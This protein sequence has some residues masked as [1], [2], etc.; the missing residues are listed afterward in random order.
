VAGIDLDAAQ[1]KVK[2][3]LSLSTNPGG[4]RRL[5]Q[6]LAAAFHPELGITLLAYCYAYYGSPAIDTLTFD[7]NF[8][9]KHDVLGGESSRYIWRPAHLDGN[10]DTSSF[11][12]GS[13]AGLGYVLAGLETASAALGLTEEDASLLPTMLAGMRAVRPALRTERAQEYVALLTRLGRELVTIAVLD[14]RLSEWCDEV[15]GRLVSPKRHQSVSEALARLET[16]VVTRVLTPSELFF[17]GQAYLDST[18]NMNADVNREDVRGPSARSAAAPAADGRAAYPP[19][20]GEQVPAVSCPVLDRLKEIVAD[21]AR[22]DAGA[23]RKE[24]AQYGVPLHSRLRLD[25]FTLASPESYEHLEQSRKKGILFD[26]MCDLK[27]RLA[28]LHYALG[29]PAFVA[30]VEQELALRDILP[31]L[32]N[33]Q[34]HSW[35]QVLDRINR[36]GINNTRSWIEEALSRGWLIVADEGEK[37]TEAELR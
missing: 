29:L 14:K 12:A 10:Q 26:R 4:R 33:V 11:I 3:L 1:V 37:R 36:L 21:A 23:F 15:L 32:E 6:E 19:D 13:V 16:G 30:E 8:I 2:E 5:T 25:T 35:K 9:R 22:V 7:V 20:G 27:I 17:L 18:E 31:K 28:D 24:V 34:V